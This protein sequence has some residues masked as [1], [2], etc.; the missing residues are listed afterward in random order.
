M[1]YQSIGGQDNIIR[2]LLCFKI[3]Y[4]PI[5]RL[6]VCE[7]I[8]SFV[9]IYPAGAAIFDKVICKKTRNPVGRGFGLL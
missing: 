9:A 5:S 4:L 6:T 8:A 1:L 7:R 2:D 3:D